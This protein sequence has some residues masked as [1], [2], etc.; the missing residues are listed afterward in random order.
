MLLLPLLCTE[1][2]LFLLLLPLLCTEVPELLL[3][4]FRLDELTL[5][6]DCEFVLAGCVLTA[7]DEP[8]FDLSGVTLAGEL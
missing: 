6:E 8:L 1:V 2:P 4:L 3:L 5:P 7:D